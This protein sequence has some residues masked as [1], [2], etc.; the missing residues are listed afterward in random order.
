MT[1]LPALHPDLARIAHRLDNGLVVL[2]N[3]TNTSVASKRPI[4][5]WTFVPER[6][7]FD[8]LSGPAVAG[9]QLSCFNLILKLIRNLLRAIVTLQAKQSN[10]H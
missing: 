2:I 10:D 9:H 1:A 4:A 6:T 7:I 5:F 3:S 8:L